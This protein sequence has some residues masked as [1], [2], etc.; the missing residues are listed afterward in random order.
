M[1]R[2]WWGLLAGA[3]MASVL[4]GCGEIKQRMAFL[5]PT[6]AAPQATSW[7]VPNGPWP[8]LTPVRFDQLAGWSGDRAAEALVAFLTSCT[9][10]NV[11]PTQTLGGQGEAAVRGGVS[12]DWP[13]GF[14]AAARTVVAGDDAAA[15]RFFETWFLQAYGISSD[16]SAQG[17]FT[18]YFEPEV[19]GARTQGGGV[20]VSAA[21]AAQGTLGAGQQP[22]FTR[23]EIERGALLQPGPGTVVAGRSDRRVLPPGAGRRAGAAAGRVDRA[24][25]L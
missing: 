4:A 22:Y 20:S 7:A 1:R 16:G 13:A 2:R 10:L 19:A 18:G 14:C 23:A 11:S 24:G 17:L 3:V 15:R 12:A 25:H 21:A 6:P 9:E 5:A 8:A